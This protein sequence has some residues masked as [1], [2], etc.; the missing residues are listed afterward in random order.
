M[1]RA[2]EKEEAEGMAS[3]NRIDQLKNNL[4][5]LPQ[6]GLFYFNDTGLLFILP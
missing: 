6:G 3:M 1:A 2:K 4:K 5:R